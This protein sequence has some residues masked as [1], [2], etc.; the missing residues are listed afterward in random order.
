MKHIPNLIT[1]LNLVSGFVGIIFAARGDI[2]SASWLIVAAMIFD[3]LDGFAARLLNAY[4]DLGKELDSLADVVSFGVAPAMII[5]HLLSNVMSPDAGILISED[6]GTSLL[7]FLPALM[8]V[9]AA[10]R[11]AK[12]NLDASQSISFKGMPTPANG[13]AVI[14]LILAMNFTE[15]PFLT[16]FTSSPFWLIVYTVVLSLLMVSRIPLLS[17]KIKNI[18]FKGNE[19]RYLLIIIIIAG[20]L[21]FGMM[22]LPLII[23]FY[24]AAS[25]VQFYLLPNSSTEKQN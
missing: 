19:G 22:V 16:A 5:F 24:I 17:L 1:S 25:L 9:C 23:P 8:P 13:I 18:S 12:F 20:Y 21:I 7:L 2:L 11:L 15:S 4:S 14:T 6:P 10:L 3:Y